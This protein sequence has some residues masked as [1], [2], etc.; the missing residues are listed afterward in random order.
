MSY[1]CGPCGVRWS[2]YQCLE[3]K[4]PICGSG[5][6]RKLA[7]PSE[8]SAEL[9]RTI[10]HERSE[11]ERIMGLYERFAAFYEAWDARAQAEVAQLEAL[12]ALEMSP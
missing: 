8:N 12:Y 10:C 11:R 4:C 9:F 5:V 7:H 3:S 2:P 1:E 6:Q